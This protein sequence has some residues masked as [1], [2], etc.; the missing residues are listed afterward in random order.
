MPL[1]SGAINNLNSFYSPHGLW[2]SIFF[3]GLA[4]FAAVALGYDF[5]VDWKRMK[6]PYKWWLKIVIAIGMVFEAFL[7]YIDMIFMCA[8]ICYWI[9]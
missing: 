7:L 9:M 4:I 1:L 2:F 6:L 3:M 5:A 8:T